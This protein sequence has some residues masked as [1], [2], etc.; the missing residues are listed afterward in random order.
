MIAVMG[1]AGNVGG[2]V[3]DLLL[4]RGERVRAFQHARPLEGLAARGAE[5][6]WGDAARPDDLGTLFDG[7]S[8]ALVLLPDQIGQERFVATRSAIAHA[9]ADSLRARPV[10][11]V[12]ML[13]SVGVDRPDVPGIPAGLKELERLLFELEEINLLVLRSALYMDYQL[14]AVPLIQAQGINGSAIDGERPLPMIATR[15]VA[16]EAAERLAR[17]DFTGH[18]AKVLLGPEDVTMREATAAIGR[19][20]G[21]PEVPY[22]QFPPGDLKGALMGGGFSDEAA[23]NLVEMQLGVNEGRFD[24][25]VERTPENTGATRLDQFLDGALGPAPA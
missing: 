5:V 9:I 8:A 21:K 4:G 2:K 14:A 11:H 25:A 19:R 15:D 1:A 13:S 7:A 16:A 24:A 18:G 17:R 3:V 20:L 23:A 10:G 6:V 12:V 22:V